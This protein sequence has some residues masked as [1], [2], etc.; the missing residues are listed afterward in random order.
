[1]SLND[2]FHLLIHT[3][4]YGVFLG[5]SF[6]T[7]GMV[8][9]RIEKK[10][11]NDFLIVL[12]WI[13][14]L[15]VAVWYFHQVNHGRFQSYLLIFVLLGGLIYYKVLRRNYQHDLKIL[16]KNGKILWRALKKVVNLLIFTPIRFIFRIIFDIMVLPKNILVRIWPKKAVDEDKKEYDEGDATATIA[17]TQIDQKSPQ[18]ST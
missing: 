11:L 18:T 5:L 3:I 15:P 1:M 9:G 17:E 16:V 2:Q 13:I 8:V 10:L 14:Q 12:Y 7:L 4:L 6:D